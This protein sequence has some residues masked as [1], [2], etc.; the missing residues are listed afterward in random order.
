MDSKELGVHCGYY[1]LFRHHGIVRA[2]DATA[3]IGANFALPEAFTVDRRKYRLLDSEDTFFFWDELIDADNRTTGFAFFL[4]ENPV[5]S[6]SR[7]VRDTANVSINGPEVHI[8]LAPG[9]QHKWECVQGFGSEIYQATDD[10][11]DCAILMMNW[12]GRHAGFDFVPNLARM[13]SLGCLGRS[14]RRPSEAPATRPPIWGVAKPP[15]QPPK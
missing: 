11:S 6:Q 12:S 7:F 3:F 10:T 13:C 8:D 2:A 15:P 9:T 14:L 1:L 4:P 5:F